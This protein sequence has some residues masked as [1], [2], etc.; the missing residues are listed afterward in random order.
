[1]KNKITYLLVFILFISTLQGVT[2]PANRAKKEIP[3]RDFTHTVFVEVGT[4]Q[5]CKPCHYWNQI[6]HDIYTSG[7]YDFQ[8]VEMIVVDHNGEVLND[9]AKDWADIYDVGSFPVS[10]LDGNYQRVINNSALFIEYL[11]DCGNRAVA[12]ISASLKVYWKGNATIQVNI[13]IKNDGETQYNG[14][15]RAAITEIESRYTTYNDDQYYF[16][17][18]DYAFDKDITITAGGTYTDSMTWNGNEHQDNYGDDFGDIVP[19][20]IQVTMGILNDNDGYVDETVMAYVSENNPPNE[21]NN[22]NPVNGAEEVDKETDLSWECSDPDGDPLTYDVYFDTTSPP[23]LVKSDHNSNS[24]DPGILDPNTT[25]YWQIV[26]KDLPGDSTDGP[27]WNFNTK[28]KTSDNNPPKVKIIKP[29]KA[30]YFGNIEII[31]RIF[32]LPL[33][34]GKITIEVEATDEDSGIE[35]VEFYIN[36]DLK[37]TDTT[38]L[39]S[40]NWIRDRLRVFHFFIIK[41]I[42]YDNEGEWDE[43]SIIVRKFL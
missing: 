11:N 35:K 20:N 8:Y 37:E 42:A 34:F 28:E 6:I 9:K 18:L 32:G 3:S 43:D 40:Y 7:E 2:I 24:Y 5:C 26:A 16:G 19:E 23:D 12:D 21:P 36:D 29:K 30:L 13:Y 31:P 15:I 14:H 17:F 38:N 27:V 41:A 33:I 22:P 25:Y 10:I 1:M 39:Y 4:S